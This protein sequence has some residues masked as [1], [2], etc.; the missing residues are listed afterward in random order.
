[1]LLGGLAAFLY[2]AYQL[3]MDLL[4]LL[5]GIQVEGIVTGQQVDYVEQRKVCRQL[6]I[7]R[8]SIRVSGHAPTQLSITAGQ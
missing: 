5:K 4:F 1:M 8:R 6:R 7:R 2:G 3:G